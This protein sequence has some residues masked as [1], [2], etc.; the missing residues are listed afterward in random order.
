MVSSVSYC[1][2][3][4]E[5]E[6]L[7]SQI[8]RALKGDVADVFDFACHHSK[9]H[10]KDHGVILEH[11]KYV[12]TTTVEPL[13]SSVV[14]FIPPNLTWHLPT[15]NILSGHLPLTLGAEV[16]LSWLLHLTLEPLA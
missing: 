5:D 12:C 14:S 3:Y 10:T 11:T 6:Y 9:K 8:I 4:Y 2:D 7:L 1:Q 13:L 15:Y 16:P